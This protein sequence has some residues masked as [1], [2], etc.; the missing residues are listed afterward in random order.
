[1]VLPYHCATPRLQ[2]RA[3]GEGTSSVPHQQCVLSSLRY[4]RFIFSVNK[5][6]RFHHS[7]LN[8]REQVKHRAILSSSSP[9]RSQA[10]YKLGQLFH[11][12]LLKIFLTYTSNK[13]LN[14]NFSTRRFAICVT[15]FYQ[16][17]HTLDWAITCSGAKYM[18]AALEGG[19]YPVFV[20][21]YSPL[22][23]LQPCD[24]GVTK[25]GCNNF[26]DY[27]VL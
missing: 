13:S 1:M 21:R 17:Y 23:F 27:F 2:C 5:K 10:P 12:L 15:H 25:C 26:L 22:C 16:T 11:M 24:V 14:K 9:K 18:R 6:K 19:H 7:K 4:I 8:K 3:W 20:P